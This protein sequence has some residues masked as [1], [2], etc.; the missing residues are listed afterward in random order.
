MAFECANVVDG[1]PADCREG[2]SY[3]L[4]KGLFFTIPGYQH[5][6]KADAGDDDVWNQGVIDKEI[7]PVHNIKEVEDLSTDDARYE[8]PG[9]DLKTLF[10][11]KRRFKVSFDLTLD[12]HK[13]LRQYGGKNFRLFW[14]DVNNN[15]L[16]TSPNGT[17]VR[18]FD[19]SFID[20]EK[21][22]VPTADTPMFTK[23]EIQLEYYDELDDSGVTI[24]P[25][26]GA[27]ADKWY[28]RDI[29]SMTK[30]TV[31]QIGTISTNSGVITVK[32][33]SLSD[34]DNEGN[35]VT[36]SPYAGLDVSTY[37][38]FEFTV[39]GTVTAPSSMTDDGDGQYSFTVT[40]IVATDTV[41]IKPTL[42][43]K[44]ESDVFTLS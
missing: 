20:V 42:T 31:E 2:N 26:Q 33:K 16:G 43:N 24:I 36:D 28:P 34:T 27:A 35:P 5:S 3:V 30:V 44:V 13:V 29:T 37:T 23:L 40:G 12:Q 19:V 22:P 8:S 38:N 10:K 18:G 7:F 4:M 32:Y 6:S 11:G 39:G 17:I 25:T 15:I 21:L 1:I 14:Y 41:Q 9:G